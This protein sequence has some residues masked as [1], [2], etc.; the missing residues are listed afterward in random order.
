MEIKERLCPDVINAAKKVKE[1][2]GNTNY[3]YHYLY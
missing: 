3:R 2:D 1:A